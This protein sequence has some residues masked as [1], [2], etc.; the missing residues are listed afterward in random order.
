ME[1]ADAGIRSKM[2]LKVIGEDDEEVDFEHS[3]SQN[4]AG[5]LHPQK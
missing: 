3:G 4:F 2:D 5:V 1:P